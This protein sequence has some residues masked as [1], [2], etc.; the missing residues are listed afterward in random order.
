MLRL[1]LYVVW[2][3]WMDQSCCVYCMILNIMCC[4][5]KKIMICGSGGYKG[6][7]FVIYLFIKVRLLMILMCVFRL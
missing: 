5:M 1:Y 3:C 4:F 2:F 6:L 7:V